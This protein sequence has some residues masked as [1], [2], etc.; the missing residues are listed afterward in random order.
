MVAEG[1]AALTRSIRVFSAVRVDVRF[2]SS[3][4]GAVHVVV[5]SPQ[6]TAVPLYTMSLPPTLIVTSLVSGVSTLICGGAPLCVDEVLLEQP[7]APS[8][9]PTALSVDATRDMWS[10]SGDAI[11]ND[12]NV[13]AWCRSSGSEPRVARASAIGGSRSGRFGAGST[14]VSHE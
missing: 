13:R 4:A 14:E 6:A 7:T 1:A 8:T 10:P 3:I 9:N 5:G 11:Y 12:G 2:A